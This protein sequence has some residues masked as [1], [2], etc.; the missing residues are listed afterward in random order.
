M[1]RLAKTG[2][3]KIHKGYQIGGKIQLEVLIHNW[4]EMGYQLRIMC[5]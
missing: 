2:F 3:H 1:T 4:F 5:A